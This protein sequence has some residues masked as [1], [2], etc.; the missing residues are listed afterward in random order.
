MDSTTIDAVLADINWDLAIG[1]LVVPIFLWKGV[2]SITKGEW[3]WDPKYKGV[4]LGG[5]FLLL[6]VWASAGLS[7]LSEVFWFFAFWTIVGSV[8]YYY[9][10]QFLPKVPLRGQIYHLPG[11]GEVTV[12]SS[13]EA[14]VPFGSVIYKTKDDVDTMVPNVVFIQQ[15]RLLD[16]RE[17]GGFLDPLEGA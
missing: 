15:A 11:V 14:H 9:W 8:P 16:G 1:L 10:T 5:L 7:G 17:I 3:P 13:R 2:R 12:V 6:G 4:S